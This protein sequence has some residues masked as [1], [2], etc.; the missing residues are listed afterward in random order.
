MGK[1]W[2]KSKKFQQRKKKSCPLFFLCFDSATTETNVGVPRWRL[3]WH[4]K[5]LLWALS[6]ARGA[7]ASGSQKCGVLTQNKAFIKTKKKKKIALFLFLWLTKKIL[8]GDIPRERTDWLNYP[9]QTHPKR[10]KKKSKIPLYR[11]LTKNLWLNLPIKKK[12]CFS[13]EFRMSAFSQYTGLEKKRKLSFLFFLQVGEW[14]K[15]KRKKRWTKRIAHLFFD[16]LFST[17]EN[18]LASR[19]IVC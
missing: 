2:I 6:F 10:N 8:T 3:T 1:P 17:F 15:K 11:I 14:R 4:L 9:E 12:I 7:V 13:F 16:F 5:S 18:L 19:G